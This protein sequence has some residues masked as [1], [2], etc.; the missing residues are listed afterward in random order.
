MKRKSVIYTDIKIESRYVYY[1]DDEDSDDD[2][3]TKRLKFSNQLKKNIENNTYNKILYENDN[4]V[5]ESYK[6]NYEKRFLRDFREIKKILKI[7]KKVTAYE[8]T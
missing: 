6:K 5:K 3:E 1:I 7:Y 8:R 4:W 2:M